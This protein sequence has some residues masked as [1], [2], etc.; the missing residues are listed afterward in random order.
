[1]SARTPPTNV[2]SYCLVFI[3]YSTYCSLK[4][5]P[6]FTY[7][8]Q[9]PYKIV[10]FMRP[11]DLSVYLVHLHILRIKSSIWQMSGTT[12]THGQ[13]T[14][15][16]KRSDWLRRGVAGSTVRAPQPRMTTGDKA[17][18][19]NEDS[20]GTLPPSAVSQ[21]PHFVLESSHLDKE[22]TRT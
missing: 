16:S 1:M 17:Q 3:L 14:R 8:L 20:W 13:S 18:A 7:L 15:W 2:L 21:F 6:F 22:E 5:S 12:N 10:H 19:G 11:Y 9:F 4:W